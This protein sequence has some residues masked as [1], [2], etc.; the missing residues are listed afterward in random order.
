MQVDVTFFFD[1]MTLLLAAIFTLCAVIGKLV[2]GIVAGADLSRLAVGIGMIPRGEVGLVFLGVGR[3]LGVVSDS[4]FAALVIVVFAT[5][6]VT[7]P[8]LKWSLRRTVE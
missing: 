2:A 4:L 3:G 6:I 5:T 7:P 8:L 1:G